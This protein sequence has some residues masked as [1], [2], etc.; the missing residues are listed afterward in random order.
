MLALSNDVVMMNDHARQVLDPGDQV[1]LLGHAAEALIAGRRPAA[2]TVDL[3]TGAQA[4]MLCRPL[5]ATGCPAAVADGVVHVKLIEQAARPRR[6]PAR[7]QPMFLPGLVGSGPLWL[8]GCGQVE[9]LYERRRMARAGGRA[10][11]RQA[12][13]GPGRAPAAEP[14]R[15][16][17]P[18]WTRPMPA[19]PDWLV[20]A[21]RELLEGDG[22]LVIR[23]VDLLS[24]RQLHAL[25]SALQ[26]ARAAGRQHA[27]RVA[28]TLSRKRGQ[29]AT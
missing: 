1:A 15:A 25:S 28:V 10:R 20:R 21:R 7:R 8:R 9:T 5:S 13:R 24:A 6:R 14:G 12:G 4:R 3:P 11:G 22:T 16:R 17:S 2:V 26:A 23:H 27:L 29:R 19:D 18:C